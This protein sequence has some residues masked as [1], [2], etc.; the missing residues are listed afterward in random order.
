MRAR[1][2]KN[3]QY[4]ASHTVYELSNPLTS[5]QGAI[6]ILNE[7]FDTLTDSERSNSLP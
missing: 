7:D 2:E 4:L 3:A 1:N 5:I 6:K